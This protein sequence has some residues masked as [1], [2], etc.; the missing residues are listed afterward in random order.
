MKVYTSEL[1]NLSVETMSLI[2]TRQVKLVIA[3]QQCFCNKFVMFLKNAFI[4]FLN[5]LSNNPTKWSNTLKQFVGK[6]PTNCLS[7]FD[8]FVGLEL[9]ELILIKKDC[10][11]D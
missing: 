5:P 11:A 2:V 1:L 6:L 4:N 9:K 3:I 10:L 8:H 7:L